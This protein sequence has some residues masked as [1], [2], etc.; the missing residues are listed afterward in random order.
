MANYLTGLFPAMTNAEYHANPAIGSSGLKL[1]A[2]SP[3]HYW[4]A[5]VDPERE[6]DAKTKPRRRGTAWHAA[7]FEPHNFDWLYAAKPDVTATSTVGQTIAAFLADPQAFASRYVPI[8]I[9]K[10]SKEGK[11]LVAEIEARGQV[12]VEKEKY[13]EAVRLAR[14]LIGLELLDPKDLD[15]VTRAAAVA[16]TN[17]NLRVILAQPGGMAEASIFFADPETGAP[18]KI[19]PDFMLPPGKLF[20]H[21]LIL[22]GKSTID[23]S[24]D[25]EGFPRQVWTLDMHYQLG[26]YTTG[27]QQHYGTSEPPAFF[28]FAQELVPPF[29]HKVYPASKAHIA[30][31]REHASQQVQRFAECLHADAWPGYPETVEPMVLPGYAQRAIEPTEPDETIEE[32]TY[33]SE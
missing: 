22:D 25:P 14:P 5:Y 1:M 16:R 17:R 9:G 6:P 27:F 24:P 11:A 32:I 12:A 8:P 33:A 29:A 4:A 30:Y 28:W 18:C 13:D 7:V 15:R 3:A 19:R 31:G 23:A 2:R 10:T 20:P 26:L 21:G